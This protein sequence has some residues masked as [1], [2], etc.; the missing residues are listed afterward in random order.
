M[1]DKWEKVALWIIGLLIL[2]AVL[3]FA[4]DFDG[5]SITFALLIVSLMIFLEAATS[6]VGKWKAY[7]I[8]V[9]ILC[10]VVIIIG[11]IFNMPISAWGKLILPIFF[12]ELITTTY[13]KKTKQ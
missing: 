12:L 2:A 11:I 4:F 13:S 6:E 3:I 5:R 8:K 7:G 9:A 1:A 10:T